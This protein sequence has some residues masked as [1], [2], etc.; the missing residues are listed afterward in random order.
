[1]VRRRLERREH[2]N[3]VPNSVLVIAFVLIAGLGYIAGTFHTQILGAIGPVFGVKVVTDTLDLSSLQTTYQTLKGNYD[4]TIDDRALIEGA[5]KGMVDALGDEY[6]VYMNKEESTTFNNDLSGNIGGGIGIELALRNDLLTIVRVLKDNPAEKAGLAVGDI[7]TKVNDESVEGQSVE[8][9][10]MKIRGEV[11]TTV[12]VSILR[13]AGLKDFTLT[14]AEVNNPSVYT[15]VTDGI[16]VMTITRFDDETGS[17]ARAAAQEFKNQNVKAVVLDLRGNGGGYITAAQEVAGLW[18]NNQVVV[19]ERANGKVV[20]ELRSGRNPMLEGLP[21]IVLVNASTASASEIV[22]GALQDL[23][24]AKLVG[25]KTFGKGSVQKLIELPGE[26][27]LKLTVAR[28]YTPKGANI[29]KQGIS[30][31]TVVGMTTEDVSAG[32]DPQ[33]DAA[34]ELLN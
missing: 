25:E 33:L 3:R 21:T 28:W 1:V 24:V 18:L 16:G 15:S 26:A 5:N 8:Q 32:R 14:R 22:A 12:K 11:G 23:G 13:A 31:D 2:T 19:S 34:K 29:S 20:D 4:G 9:T 6:T 17:L 27:E 30:P 10:V 7:V